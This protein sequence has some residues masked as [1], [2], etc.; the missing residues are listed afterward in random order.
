MIF[1]PFEVAIKIA[2]ALGIGVLVGLERQ[3]SQKDV[4]VRTFSIT[5]LLGCLSVLISLQLAE[6]CLVGV[7]LLVVF[8]NGR[9]LLVDR[10][11]E[12]TTSV[13]L[14]VIF[15]LGVLAGLG[16]L[17]TPIASAILMT[18]LLAWKTELQR[19]AGDLKLSEI[20]GA[21]LLGLIG[22]VI[23]PLLP[24]RFIDSWHLLNPRQSWLIV[25]IVAGLGFANY[26]LLRV[27][28]NRGLYYT[29]VLGGLVNS[30]AT[31]AELSRTVSSDDSGENNTIVALV[32]LTSIAMFVRNLVILAM[33]ARAAVSI[34][35]WPL[36]AMTVGAVIFAW[37]NRERST[38][39]VR[40]LRLDSPVS[41][42]HVL[43]FGALFILMEIVGTIGARYLG[44]FG[45]LALS[46]LGGTVS[47]ASTTAAAATMA[48]HGKLSPDVAGVATVFASI[49][50]ALVNLPLVQRQTHNKQLTRTLAAISLLL[51][52]AGLAVLAIR[53]RYR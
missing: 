10:S 21:V 7:L 32:L 15:I 31:V 5:A 45:F 1:P 52:V 41:L 33:F 49:A 22:F 30:T 36:L 11:L 23:Y 2:I 50:S 6:I 17:F 37:K 35:I 26:V 43:N 8:M 4:G 39:P 27:F 24:N 51:V 14:I 42:R 18:M 29:A 28:S 19:F 40:S 38:E 3:W 13:A 34:A 12:I 53:Q 44:K 9:S 48:I 47:S 25:I 46:L 16:H 20:R